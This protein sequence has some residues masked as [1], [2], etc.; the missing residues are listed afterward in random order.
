MNFASMAPRSPPS[1]SPTASS[2][3]P[4]PSRSGALRLAAAPQRLEAARLLSQVP[5]ALG[6]N[7]VEQR[8]NGRGRCLLGRGDG[9][10]Q[11]LAELAG[12]RFV[13]RGVPS[14]LREQA[15]TH[16]LDRVAL[17]PSARHGLVAVA[18]GVVAR[19][20]RADPVGEA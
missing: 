12:E 8:R 19:R 3:A 2:S 20:V 10:V 7:V 11:L 13:A 5:R 4:T 9:D 1:S 18:T 14:A 16:E 17:L 6:V 15:G